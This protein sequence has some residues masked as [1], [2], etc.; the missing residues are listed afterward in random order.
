MLND[1][2][3]I[4]DEL[5]K[6]AN[7]VVKQSR[8]NLTRLK[9]NS[10]RKLYDSIKGNVK[11]SANSIDVE[12]EMLP[13]GDFQ[14]KGVSGV[15]KKYNTKFKYTNKM[16]PAKAFDKWTI[17]K[18]LAPRDKDG[19]FITRKSLNF[20]IARHVY[21][22]GI[23]PSLFFTKPFESALKRLDK[24]IVKAYALELDDFIDFTLKR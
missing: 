21:L 5:K 13:Y 22:Y 15:K 11:V 1:K 7:Y 20:A 19:K 10:S 6:F 24:D 16:P 18:G 9:K 2:Q 14:D 8:S 23:K 3:Y 12:F 17:K 4:E